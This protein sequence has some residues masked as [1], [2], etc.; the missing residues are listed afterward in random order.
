MKYGFHVVDNGPVSRCDLWKDG[1]YFLETGEAIV[2]DYFI[3]S[4]N[5]FLGNMIPTIS[6][7]W[8]IPIN[9]KIW[10]S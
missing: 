6:S 8:P 5:Y 1:I 4:I 3:S 9:K 10:T 7:F 2:A